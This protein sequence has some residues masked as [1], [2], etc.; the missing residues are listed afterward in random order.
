MLLSDVVNV[1]GDR[2]LSEFP[3]GCTV[4]DTVNLFAEHNLKLTLTSTGDDLN[5]ALDAMT[6]IHRTLLCE[7]Q[8]DASRACV[9]Q[10]IGGGLVIE[11]TA[12]DEIQPEAE[13]ELTLDRKT[14]TTG[15]I[16]GSVILMCVFM[17]STLSVNEGTDWAGIKDIAIEIGKTIFGINT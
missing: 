9:I 14:I 4:R 12:P 11:S 1:L 8:L 6:E 7:A 17:L 13:T 2:P 15:L 10:P 5:R 16:V 3:W